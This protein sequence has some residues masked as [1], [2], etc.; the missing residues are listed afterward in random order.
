V[1]D[2]R[3]PTELGSA[4]GPVPESARKLADALD[5]RAAGATIVEQTLALIFPDRRADP[6][7]VDAITRSGI[8][9]VDAI[10]RIIAGRAPLDDVTPLGALAFAETAA[11][12]G[13]A[14]SEVERVYRVGTTLV[15][16]AW[17]AEA[18]AYAERTG[19]PITELVEAPTM[20]IHAY[21][22]A[23]LTPTLARYD[24][25][26][27]DARRT[28]EQLTRSI[29][30]QALDGTSAVDD[31]EVAHALGVG[32]GGWFVALV[33]RTA[34]L[35]H[36]RTVE[37][38]KRAA[39]AGS[40]ITYQHGPTEWIVWLWRAEP[41][42]ADVLAQVGRA[43]AGT[44]D[45]VAASDP[46]GGATGLSTT[47][48]DAIEAARLQGLLGEDHRFL[49]FRD[50]RLESLML[51]NPEEAERFVASELGALA[52]DTARAGRLRDTAM[53]WLSS[54]SHVATA[55]A[56]RLH[57]HT[58]RNRISQAEERLG[59]AL[60]SRRTEILVALRLKRMLE[61]EGRT[62]GVRG[63]GAA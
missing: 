10:W 33:V 48:R 51:K 32:V 5:P 44:P 6:M 47:G 9:N 1:A 13:V 4:L 50:V 58:V 61:V 56:L 23:L 28:R 42:A 60:A 16:L 49:L 45:L 62:T 26:R 30:R 19:T 54:G 21:I 14:A 52:D 29:V 55:A 17:Y 27:A 24:A 53:I 31:Q 12:A 25:T 15:W 22:D 18:R 39:D 37:P 57:E 20:I 43:L 2:A 41:F 35:D 38:A 7:F 59:V 40:A 8:D 46:A 36:D 3:T 63:G 34:R 11:R